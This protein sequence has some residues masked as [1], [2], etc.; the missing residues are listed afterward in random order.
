MAQ[1]V[2]PLSLRLG[3]N[4]RHDSSWFA[5]TNYTKLIYK[6]FYI[7]NYIDNFFRNGKRKGFRVKGFFNARTVIEMLPSKLKVYAFIYK[8]KSRKKA[9][10]FGRKKHGTGLQNRIQSLQS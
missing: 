4:R 2:N 7:K 1:K 5:D 9:N 6:E 8:P 10:T 3:V